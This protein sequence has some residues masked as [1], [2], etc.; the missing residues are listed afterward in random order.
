[1]IRPCAEMTRTCRLTLN[2]SRMTDARL[3]S[4]SDEVAA[5]LALRQHG[6][7]EEPRVEERHALARTPCSASGS[8]MPKFCW[9]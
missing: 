7:D 8:G 9:S 2:R 3:S 4:T 5:R 1:M 6:G